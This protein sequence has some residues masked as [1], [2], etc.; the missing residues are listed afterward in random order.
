[1]L[2][3]KELCLWPTSDSSDGRHSPSF[4]IEKAQEERA[5]NLHEGKEKHLALVCKNNLERECLYNGLIMNGIKIP[6]VSYASIDSE[7]SLCGANVILMHIGSRCIADP[8]VTEEI[9]STIRKLQSIPLVLLAEREDWR[10]VVRAMEIGVRGYIPTSV[11]IRICVEAIHLAIVGGMYIPASILM[12]QS[13]YNA[14][15]VMWG[16]MLTAREI[17]VVQAIRVG[18]SNKVIA[19]DLHMSEGTVKAHVHNIMKKLGAVNRTE[20][21]C[22]LNQIYRN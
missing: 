4:S 20:V 18:K 9:E 12:K 21:A 17:E 5:T 7:T 3:A 2:E 13:D 10:Q 8:A 19:Y 1:M 22:M 6:V 15:D 11:D 14:E 16:G